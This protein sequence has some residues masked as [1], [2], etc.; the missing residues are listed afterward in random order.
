MSYKV[1]IAGVIILLFA[2]IMYRGDRLLK[3]KRKLDRQ[4]EDI[5]G[6]MDELFENVIYQGGFPPM[7]KPAR[8]S[9]GFTG[10]ELVMYNKAGENG[11]IGYDSIKKLDIFTTQVERKRKFSLMAYGPLAL[12]LNRPTLRHFFTIE[13]NDVNGKDN[14]MV[15]IVGTRVIAARMYNLIEPHLNPDKPDKPK[16]KHKK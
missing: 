7:P 14:I 1:V 11:R 2:F 3:A 16:L 4:M 9:F 15:A 6:P 10:S 5:Y 12:L 13:Y 8:L